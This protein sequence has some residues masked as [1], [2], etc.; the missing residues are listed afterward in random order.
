MKKLAF[1]LLAFGS[2]SAFAQNNNFKRNPIAVVMEG[3]IYQNQI[4]IEKILS[5][6]LELLEAANIHQSLKCEK[7]K[8]HGVSV[9]G[10]RSRCRNN[11]TGKKV[12]TV[13]VDLHDS[14]LEFSIRTARNQ[15]INIPS[16]IEN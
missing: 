10:F 8:H 4:R 15:T 1:T 12:V 3:E 5:Q 13:F 2:I 9:Y 16:E 14:E 6:K 11:L 7:I